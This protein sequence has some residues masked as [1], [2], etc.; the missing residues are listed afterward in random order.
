MSFAI[1]SLIGCTKNELI[2]KMECDI[3]EVNEIGWLFRLHGYSFLSIK[4]YYFYFKN[5][6]VIY[7]KRSR[8]RKKLL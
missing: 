6:K 7:I 4:Y 5:D 1:N 2:S 8:F 3:I